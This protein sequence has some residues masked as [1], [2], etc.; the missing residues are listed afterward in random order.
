MKVL[1]KTLNACIL[2]SLLLAVSCQD[3][4]PQSNTKK[5][6]NNKATVEKV[7]EKSSEIS[8]AVITKQ[9]IKMQQMQEDMNTRMEEMI[10]AKMEIT[11]DEIT[12]ELEERLQERLEQRELQEV[13]VEQREIEAPS[14]PKSLNTQDKIMSEVELRIDQKVTESM[15]RQEN[16]ENISTKLQLDVSA[17]LDSEIEKSINS[18]VDSVMKDRANNEV[19]LSDETKIK[20]STVTTQAVA[21]DVVA[22]EA[23]Q[24][25]IAQGSLDLENDLE[26]GLVD[27]SLDLEKSISAQIEADLCEQNIYC[28]TK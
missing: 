22:D 27:Y 21:Q 3:N 17:K 7:E 15:A 12:A 10:Q 16:L 14:L 25:Q 11:S 4:K 24:K 6:S 19:T 18:L 23:V 2:G 9:Q 26:L 1:P 13:V 20:L 5:N 8:Q 28:S